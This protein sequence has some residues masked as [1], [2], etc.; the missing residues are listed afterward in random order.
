MAFFVCVQAAE[1]VSSILH[2]SDEI[3]IITTYIYI[4]IYTL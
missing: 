3:Y 2:M 1:S 4:Y